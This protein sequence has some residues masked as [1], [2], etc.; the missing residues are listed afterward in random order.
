MA[1]RQTL[2]GALKIKLIV[3]NFD[4]L[5]FMDWVSNRWAS[6]KLENLYG[7]LSD[8]QDAVVFA[9]RKVLASEGRSLSTGVENDLRNRI[10]LNL[11]VLQAIDKM[12]L[13]DDAAG[14]PFIP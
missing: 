1:T 14:S 7:D 9:T 8:A 13:A 11:T 2:G 3:D 12:V 5:E 10:A 6:T 4:R